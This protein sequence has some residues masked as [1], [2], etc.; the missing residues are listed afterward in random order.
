MTLNFRGERGEGP[1]GS[2]TRNAGKPDAGEE[3]TVQHTDVKP[4]WMHDEYAMLFTNITPISLAFKKK[5][6]AEQS[7]IW[8]KNEFA[9]LV[10]WEGPN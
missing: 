4:C 5:K 10:S 9:I 1:R 3:H 7:Y 2:R 6:K 8:L